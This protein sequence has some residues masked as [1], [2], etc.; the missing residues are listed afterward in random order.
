MKVTIVTVQYFW[1]ILL[2][3]KNSVLS[4]TFL[5]E[6][7]VNTFVYVVISLLFVF[8]FLVPQITQHFSSQWEK[9]PRF[10]HDGRMMGFGWG[11]EGGPW[12]ERGAP[13]IES[14]GAPG[15]VGLTRPATNDGA[16][17]A[18]AAVTL[19]YK[20]ASILMFA[21]ISYIDL[22]TVEL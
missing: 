5:C 19:A 22:I 1:Y 2:C 3:P 8:F 6:S 11:L 16:A 14:R 4:A 18:G 10:Q 15:D 20:P 13:P 12:R 21:I 17:D 9:R 7:E